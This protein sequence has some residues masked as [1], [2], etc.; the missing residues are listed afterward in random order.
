[1]RSA[2]CTKVQPFPA[3]C[4]NTAPRL[5]SR[6]SILVLFTVASSEAMSLGD[7]SIGDRRGHYHRGTTA[8]IAS[9][10]SPDRNVPILNPIEMSSFSVLSFTYFVSPFVSAG[11][12]SY[13]VGLG[14]SE[15][16]RSPKGGASRAKRRPRPTACG[17]STG[18]SA[19]DGAALVSTSSSSPPWPLEVRPLAFSGAGVLGSLA[20]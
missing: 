2:A 14:R 12:V 11:V 5:N 6:S 17:Q 16:L 15:A 8:L 19:R 9:V 18:P 13:A 4:D 7:I 10:S 20:S 1:M 3:T